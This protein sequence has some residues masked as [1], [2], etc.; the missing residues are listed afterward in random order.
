MSLFDSNLIQKNINIF[1]NIDTIASCFTFTYKGKLPSQ[2]DS[3]SL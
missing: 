2:I 3:S 1:D